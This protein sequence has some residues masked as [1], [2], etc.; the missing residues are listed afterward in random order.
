MGE[1]DAV[2]ENRTKLEPWNTTMPLFSIF[3]NF[4]RNTVA[5]AAEE[6]FRVP[7]EV[8]GEDEIQRLY[9][10]SWN[11]KVKLHRL[12]KSRFYLY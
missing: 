9:Q 10:V 5:T 6:T 11:P 3:G 2:I 8:V 1:K 12:G 4:I 7:R